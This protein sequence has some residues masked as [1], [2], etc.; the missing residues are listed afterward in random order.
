MPPLNANPIVLQYPSVVHLTHGRDR[1]TWPCHRHRY[2]QQDYLVLRR[3]GW[4]DREFYFGLPTT[5]TR[6][7]ILK[8]HSQEMGG[9]RRRW[10]SRGQGALTTLATM[11]YGDADLRVLHGTKMMPFDRYRRFGVGHPL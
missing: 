1:R 2:N 4:F 8:Y 7:K 6:E 5:D 3:P 11:S 9:L 10:R